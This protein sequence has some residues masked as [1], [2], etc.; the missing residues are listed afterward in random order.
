[1]KARGKIEAG[2]VCTKYDQIDTLVKGGRY[3]N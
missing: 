2:E 1:M 3:I